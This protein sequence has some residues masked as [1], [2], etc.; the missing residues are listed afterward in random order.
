MEK[1]TALSFTLKLFTIINC[2]LLIHSLSFAA[3]RQDKKHANLYS[4]YPTKAITNDKILPNTPPESG[5][6]S[7]DLFLRACRG[8]YE[9]VSF[10]VYAHQ[11]LQQLQVTVGDLTNSKQQVIPASAVELHVVKC[12]LQSGAVS[13]FEK[14]KCLLVPELLLKDDNLVKV[15]VAAQKQYL[16]TV[17]STGRPRYDQLNVASAQA[18]TWLA[19]NCRP[20]DAKDLQPVDLGAKMGKQFW[21]TVHVPENAAPGQYAGKITLTPANAPATELTLNLQVLPFALEKPMLRYAMYYRGCFSST[22]NGRTPSSTPIDPN[23]KSSQQYLVEMQD[24][25]AHGIEFP[26]TYERN[27]QYL[28]QQ[29]AIRAQ[30]GLPTGTLYHVGITAQDYRK[31]TGWDI[32]RWQQVIRNC[33]NTIKAFGYN[34]LYVYGIDNTNDTMLVSERQIW[35]AA[36]QI[37][38]KIFVACYASAYSLNPPDLPMVSCWP[39]NMNFCNGITPGNLTVTANFHSI[40]LPVFGRSSPPT[41]TIQPETYRRNYGLY[42]WKQNYDGAMNY[43]YQASYGAF[44]WNNFQTSGSRNNMCTYPTVDGV[45][46][47]LGWE[48]FRE[49]VDDVRYLTTLL[50]AIREAR[51][52]KKTL[53]AEAHKWINFLVTWGDLYNIRQTMFDFIS[54]LVK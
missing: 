29:L 14:D 42:Q 24:L 45:V 44:C 39:N 18:S 27:M 22:L 38:A 43:A 49:G 1:I 4:I 36:R 8:E 19:Q 53:A 6:F 25:K 54:L 20:Q 48:A 15:D 16:R 9:P 11:Q 32:P 17:D 47:T 52:E 23:I 12:W 21:V 26:T 34:E 33:Q 40:H 37:G 51:P 7:K 46:S 50:K 28:K 2:I 41:G 31:S 5:S 35:A 13:I 10:V 30:A 3:T